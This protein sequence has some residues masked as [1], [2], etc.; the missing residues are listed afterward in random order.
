MVNLIKLEDTGRNIADLICN[1]ISLPSIDKE[2]RQSI[3]LMTSLRMRGYEKAADQLNERINRFADFRQKE[4]KCYVLQ[5]FKNC[6][7]V[8]DDLSKGFIELSDSAIRIWFFDGND[9]VLF[10]QLLEVLRDK[11][12]SSSEI[13]IS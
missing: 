5:Q 1:G 8:T 3:I 12:G 9:P 10:I 6:F 7:F 11:I 4:R 13:V 2:D